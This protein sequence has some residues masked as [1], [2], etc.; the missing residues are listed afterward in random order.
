MQFVLLGILR[1]AD[2]QASPRRLYY[3]WRGY[4]TIL[5]NVLKIPNVKTHIP[6]AQ[7]MIHPTAVL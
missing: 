2:F 3:E 4:H 5:P 6:Q 7:H 1:S